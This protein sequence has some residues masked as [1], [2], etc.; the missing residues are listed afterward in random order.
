M[1]IHDYLYMPIIM[2][3]HT[4]PRT[5]HNRNY[6]YVN[7]HRIVWDYGYLYSG[8]HRYLSQCVVSFVS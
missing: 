1:V 3:T 7:L 5:S 6:H 2:Y 4:V 8:Y